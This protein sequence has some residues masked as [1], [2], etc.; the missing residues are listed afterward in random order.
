MLP[1]LSRAS[2]HTTVEGFLL[3]TELK[4]AMIFFLVP[5]Y[6]LVYSNHLKSLMHLLVICTL[7]EL[8]STRLIRYFSNLPYLLLPEYKLH[9]THGGCRHLGAAY[10]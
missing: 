10:R 8:C 4:T 9:G 1:F 2:L 3:Y 5:E 7:V 6:S